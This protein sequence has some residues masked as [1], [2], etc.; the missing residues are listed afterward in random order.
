MSVEIPTQPVGFLPSDWMTGRELLSGEDSE[1]ESG[2][3]QI[4]SEGHYLWSQRVKVLYGLPQHHNLVAHV[5]TNKA[6]LETI[7]GPIKINVSPGVSTI[8]LEYDAEDIKLQLKSGYGDS[9]VTTVNTW[10]CSYLGLV[11]SNTTGVT[12]SL[13][14]LAAKNSSRG[15]LWSCRI[16]ELAMDLLT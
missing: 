8:K 16:V 2:Y 7:I 4:V 1:S 5:D 3:R 10:S 9:A 15:Y 12:T 13:Q 11:L 6:S 14:V